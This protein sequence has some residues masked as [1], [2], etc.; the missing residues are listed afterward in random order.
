MLT[1]TNQRTDSGSTT[2]NMFNQIDLGMSGSSVVGTPGSVAVTSPDRQ[3]I[4]TITTSTIRNTTVVDYNDVSGTGRGSSFVVDDNRNNGILPTIIP[5]ES[6]DGIRGI[7][8][9]TDTFIRSNTNT[10]TDISG[11]ESSKYRNKFGAIASTSNTASTD[12]AF[13]SNIQGISGVNG[14][15]ERTIRWEYNADCNCQ[16]PVAAD[17]RV[18]IQLLFD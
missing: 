11:L 15:T 2:D 12:N 3:N 16:V 9:I 7:N 10:G 14:I 1:G 8:T 18:G 4:N 5:R 6:T 13:N 17:R